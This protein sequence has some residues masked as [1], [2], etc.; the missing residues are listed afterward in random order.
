MKIPIKNKIAILSCLFILNIILRNQVVFNEIG[1][2][3]TLMHLMVNSLSEYGSAKWIL[4]P[5]SIFGIY[6]ASYTSAMH[7]LLSGFFQLSALDMRLIIYSYCIIIGLFSMATSYLMASEIYDD[8]LYKL[9]VAFAFSLSPGVLGYTTWTIPARGLLVILVPL[10]IFMILRCRKSFK[11]V[12]LT[13]ILGLFLFSTHHLFYFLFPVIFAFVL[14]YVMSKVMH[15]NTTFGQLSI[16]SLPIIT[17][18]GFVLMFFI[19]FFTGKFIEH[20]RYSAFYIS[21]LRYTGLFFIPALGGIAY[22]IFKR[23]KS[24]S[25]WFLVLSLMFLTVFVYEQTYM[26]WFLPIFIISFA[27][28]GVINIINNYSRMPLISCVI[29]LFIVLSVAFSGYYQFINDYDDY[30]YIEKYIEDS[31]YETGLW[32]KAHLNEPATSNDVYFG[33]L[34]FSVS[35]TSHILTDSTIL[36]NVHG[37]YSINVSDFERYPITSEEFWFSGY[38]G[39]DYGLIK[40]ERVQK[41]WEDDYSIKYFIEN[42][43]ANGRIIWNHKNTVSPLLE[44]AHSQNKIYDNE[45]ASIWTLDWSNEI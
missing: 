33:R 23:Y 16:N 18:I 6:P 28:I 25:E 20:T 34:I 40:W 13:L 36:N 30:A 45:V 26:K 12:P 3:S 4:D 35:D 42:N 9:L 1:I 29:F 14:L 32:S 15:K 24:F 44:F 21:Y 22:L 11:Y 17:I 19:P 41:R 27:G 39:K 43:R 31:I 10:F 38:K 8:D 37:F 2:D 5:L 7:F